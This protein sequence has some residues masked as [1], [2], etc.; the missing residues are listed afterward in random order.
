VR[1]VQKE[2]GAVFAFGRWLV[3]AVELS[4]SRV[5]VLALELKFGHGCRSRLT[6]AGV[7]KLARRPVLTDRTTIKPSGAL[8][9]ST[10]H[11][12][13]SLA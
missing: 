4:L 8:I 11:S 10:R 12:S 5:R 9:D 3:V 1:E 2:L 6:W 13:P 7:K